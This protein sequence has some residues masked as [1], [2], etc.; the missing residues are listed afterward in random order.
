[1]K[2]Y[3]IFFTS[4]IL[5]CRYTL[6]CYHSILR[7][8]SVEMEPTEVSQCRAFV[9][10]LTHNRQGSNM[11]CYFGSNLKVDG[12]RAIFMIFQNSSVR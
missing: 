2:N 8:M 5:S 6:K 1:M 4:T 7:S 12:G 10:K 9:A 11:Y 3:T